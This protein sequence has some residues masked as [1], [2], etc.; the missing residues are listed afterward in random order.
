MWD[1]EHDDAECAEWAQQVV[2]RLICRA[3]VE[4]EA[5]EP[6]VVRRVAK[7]VQ[8]ISEEDKND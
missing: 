5:Q 6:G 4:A 2:D 1:E 7:Y 8:R 3:A